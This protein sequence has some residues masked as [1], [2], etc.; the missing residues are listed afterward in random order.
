MNK[1][2]AYYFPT[3]LYTLLLL[4]L[5]FLSWI[6]GVVHIVD[7]DNALNSLM[8][9]EGVRWAVGNSVQ[10]V[11]D[12][13]WGSAMLLLVVVA[14]LDCSGLLRLL[15][16]L[17]H[18]HPITV[19]RRRAAIM[20]FFMLLLYVGIISLSAISPW[21]LLMSVTS[22]I[23]ASPLLRG[24]LLL[25]FV[26]TLFVTLMYGYV[27]GNFRTATDV[28]CGVGRCVARFVPALLA[29][30]PATA[31]LSCLQYMNLFVFLDIDNSV[32]QYMADILYVF[33]FLFVGYLELKQD[34]DR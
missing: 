8:T 3:L 19:N 17:L 11:N 14:M 21:R 20:A 24:W 29:M 18:L 7:G 32:A 28:M 2:G 27:Y 5:W 15:G 16:D 25:F 31:I 10:A 12:A 30:L 34:W 4:L 23:T 33:P 9:G 1:R 13:P 22:D 26:G 6:I